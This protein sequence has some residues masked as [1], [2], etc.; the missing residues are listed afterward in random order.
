MHFYLN[1]TIA[2]ACFAA[3]AF[4]IK[5]EPA[6]PVS[7]Y[8]RFRQPGKYVAYVVKQAGKGGRVGARSPADRRLINIYDFVYKLYAL[9]SLE[10]AMMKAA[11]VQAV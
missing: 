5:A 8:F 1:N 4:H 7:S 2:L 9:Q 6:R 10:A 11:S 3:T